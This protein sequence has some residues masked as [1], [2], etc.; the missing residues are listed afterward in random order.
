MNGKMGAGHWILIA[1]VVLLLV[2][3]WGFNPKSIYEGAIGT[4]VPGVP[5]AN[6]PS[7]QCIGTDTTTYT[8]QLD[9]KYN[10]G[11]TELSSST[12]DGIAIF[13]DNVRKDGTYGDGDS[14][15]LSPG[16]NIKAYYFDDTMDNTMVSANTVSWSFIVPCKGTKDDMIKIIDITTSPTINILSDVYGDA[17]EDGSAWAFSVGDTKTGTFKITGVSKKGLGSPEGKLCIVFDANKTE[18]KDVILT[19]PFVKANCKPGAYTVASTDSETWSFEFSALEG[20]KVL[21]SSLTVEMES[22][23]GQASADS[24]VNWLNLTIFDQQWFYDSDKGVMG[25]GYENEDNAL[26]GA[27][28]VVD[29]VRI[30]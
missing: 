30:T 24:T 21:D 6:V 5:E 14:M 15:T 4:A 9:D 22:S 27:A 10:A 7:G 28:N 1:A 25:L 18:V 13:V 29:S 23:P 2:T 12:E 17:S 20:V 11:G 8:I 16:Q 26:I 3:A 19:S